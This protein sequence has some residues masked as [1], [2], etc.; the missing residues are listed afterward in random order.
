MNKLQGTILSFILLLIALIPVWLFLGVR[1]FLEPS[2]F[3]QNLVLF[4][5]G[6]Y[7]LGAIQIILLVG[8]VAAIYMIW[9]EIH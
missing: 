4:G 1:Y 7:L 5:I 2:G 6:V 8:Y 9:S 3:W